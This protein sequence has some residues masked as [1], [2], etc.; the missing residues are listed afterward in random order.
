MN[1]SIKINSIYCGPIIGGRINKEDDS[2]FMCSIADNDIRLERRPAFYISNSP[3]THLGVYSARI[4]NRI[5]QVYGHYN[6]GIGIETNY[7]S[8]RQA[9]EIVNQRSGYYN[10][11]LVSLNLNLKKAQIHRTHIVC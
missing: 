7:G 9:T 6:E 5:W 2:V 11:K 1:N 3:E 8:F 10:R 4:G